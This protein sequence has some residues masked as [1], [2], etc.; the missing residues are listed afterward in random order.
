MRL[1]VFMC[2]FIVTACSNGANL[3]DG[4][5]GLAAGTS[6]VIGV[7]LAALAV[8][9]SNVFFADYLNVQFIPGSE[10]LVIFAAAFYVFLYNKKLFFLVIFVKNERN[11]IFL[12]LKLSWF[13]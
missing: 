6:S 11:K 9:S 8:V 3:T 4:I 1:F 2:I 10:E 13:I 12:V 7:A 5:D